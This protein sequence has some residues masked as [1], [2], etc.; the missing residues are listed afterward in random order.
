MQRG[1]LIVLEGIDG[2]GKSTQAQELQDALEAKGH[3]I[4]MQ[5]PDRISATGD[6]IDAYL[7][8]ESEISHWSA[9]TLFSAN[10]WEMVPLINAYLELGTTVILDRYAYSGIAYSL[11]KGVVRT[12]VT[13]PDRGLPRPDQVFLIDVPADV[14]LARLWHREDRAERHDR[15]EMLEAVRFNYESMS[16]RWT[17]IDGTQP[18]SEV[19]A[20]ILSTLQTH[21]DGPVGR[22]ELDLSEIE[23]MV[24]SD[25]D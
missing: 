25:E 12:W 23:I 13:E 21:Q 2:S 22:L 6:V 17:K 8:G 3:A 9:H 4:V 15:L 19:T 14:A 10:R 20:Q 16:E 24:L 18:A 11:A 1:S 5:C 7:E